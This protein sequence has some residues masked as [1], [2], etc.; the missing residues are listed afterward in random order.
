MQPARV[1][2]AARALRSIPAR[3]GDVVPPVPEVAQVDG[4]A[5]AP[6]DERA[7]NERARVGVR[8]VQRVGAA[9][10]DG[11]VAGGPDEAAELRDG[12][13]ALVDPESLDLGAADGPLLRIE[14]LGAHE[15]RAAGDPGH[16]RL[17]PAGL[18]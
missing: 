4:S 18:G 11:D 8:V 10:G 16:A 9:L 1:R 3:T 12:D 15:E 6:E 13:R 14:V 5:R 7:G 2:I 17:A